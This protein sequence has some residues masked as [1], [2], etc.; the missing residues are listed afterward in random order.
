[1]ATIPCPECG[2]IL[3]VPDEHLDK[4]GTCKHCQGHIILRRPFY[5][6]AIDFETTGLDASE[7]EVLEVAGVLFDAVTGHPIDHFCELVCPAVP[8][9]KKASQINGIT[10]KMVKDCRPPASVIK[11]FLI[12][13]SRANL[14]I[15]H[16]APFEA[17]YLIQAASRYGTPLPAAP[18][19]DTLAWSRETIT[20]VDDHKLG[21][22]MSALEVNTAGLHR[23]AADTEGLRQ[24]TLYMLRH[25]ADKPRDLKK[26]ALNVS[27]MAAQR[28]NRPQWGAA[29]AS[30]PAT[31]RQID[32]LRD[33]GATPSQMRGLNKAQASEL[34]EELQSGQRPGAYKPL[35]PPSSWWPLFLKPLTHEEQLLREAKRQTRIARSSQSQQS[36]CM[37]GCLILIILIF[38]PGILAGALALFGLGALAQ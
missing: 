6:A 32:Y 34:I 13:L 22:L 38:F 4:S 17:S 16:N 3:N 21:T 20:F 33:L 5:V 31:D 30:N 27:K 28:A 7:N 9:S 36:C 11:D 24:L 26:R 8:I 23:A 12:W 1:M 14:L 18:M 25:A 15:A 19:V 29:Q 2:Q 37:L 10:R 35:A